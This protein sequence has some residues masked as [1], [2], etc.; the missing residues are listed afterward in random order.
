M[1]DSVSEVRFFKWYPIRKILLQMHNKVRRY[2]FL[3]KRRKLMNKLFLTKPAY[4]RGLMD[5]KYE[6]WKFPFLNIFDT[7]SEVSDNDIDIDNFLEGIVNQ[8]QQTLENFEKDLMG[9]VK[10]LLSDLCKNVKKKTVTDDDIF[11]Y[12][13]HKPLI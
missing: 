4:S 7:K 2:M 8:L 13:K 9:K 10:S 12:D 3:E 11:K 1:F 5:L 6:I